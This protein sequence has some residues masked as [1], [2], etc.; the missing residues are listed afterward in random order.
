MVRSSD[1]VQTPPNIDDQALNVLRGLSRQL[2]DPA[3]ERDDAL[4]VKAAATADAALLATERLIGAKLDAAARNFA[5]LKENL[6]AKGLDARTANATK[7]A[8]LASQ[9]KL[10]IQGQ[11]AAGYV[12]VG[13][14]NARLAAAN[15]HTTNKPTKF[16]LKW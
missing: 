5:L 15:A 2:V 8:Q 11:L 1:D 7:H 12:F 16:L 13:L 3:W 6:R 10:A 14:D 4:A 9:N